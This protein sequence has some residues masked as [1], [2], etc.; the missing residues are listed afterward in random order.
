MNELTW[1]AQCPL[2][3]FETVAATYNLLASE[4]DLSAALEKLTP[5]R[6]VLDVTGLPEQYGD[7]A[8]GPDAPLALRAWLLKAGFYQAIGEF[9]NSPKS[10]TGSRR[11]TRPT[12]TGE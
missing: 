2:P 6:V 12:P 9:V 10:S 11:S 3:G 4:S 5:G 7:D 8:F 1:T